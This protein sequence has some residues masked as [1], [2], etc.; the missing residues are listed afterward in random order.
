MYFWK[1]L[2]FRKSNTFVWKYEIFLNFHVF[3]D[4]SR[5]FEISRF[6]ILFLWKKKHVGF[7]CHLKI[8]SPEWVSDP[9]YH[10]CYLTSRNCSCILP[11]VSASGG[12]PRSGYPSDWDIMTILTKTSKIS[13]ISEI[14]R[15]KIETIFSRQIILSPPNRFSWTSKWS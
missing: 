8:D 12:N 3:F 10:V 7:F 14:L 5:I 13:R 6:P 2:I 15:K 9:R 4:N 1:F 11:A